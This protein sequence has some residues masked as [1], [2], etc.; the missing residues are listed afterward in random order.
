MNRLFVAKLPHHIVNDIIDYSKEIACKITAINKESIRNVK[1]TV[2]V[3]S[4]L[5]STENIVTSQL[6]NFNTRYARKKH[7][8]NSAHY[9]APK[10]ISVNGDKTFQYVPILDTLKNLFSNKDFRNEYFAYNNNHTCKEDIYE[11]FCCGRN[12][13]NSEFFQSHKNNIQIQI[14]FDDVQLTSPL[15]TKP[16]SISA[17]YFFVRNVPPN[18]TSKLDNIY[19]VALCDSK[20]VKTNGCNTILKHFVDDIKTLETEGLEIDDEEN[21]NKIVFK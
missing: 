21:R 18:F 2:D 11:R 20:I 10:T 14:Y 6:N 16:H 19:L 8:E 3:D 1:P 12:Y 9:V 7:F 17:I 4:I 15:E 5:D 13:K